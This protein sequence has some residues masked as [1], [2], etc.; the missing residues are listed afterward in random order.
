MGFNK[1][2]FKIIFIMGIIIGVVAFSGCLTDT[3]YQTEN[4][5]FM[6]NF[7]I[8]GDV[9]NPLS[10]GCMKQ[11][12]MNELTVDGE[13]VNAISLYAII[14]KSDPISKN[15][16][17][18]FKSHDGF[19]A[20]ICGNQIQASYIIFDNTDGWCVI[21]LN[22]TAT[23]NV[24]NI[25]EI[26]I[27]SLLDE[28]EWRDGIGIITPYRNIGSKTIGE[29]L[30]SGYEIRRFYKGGPGVEYRIGVHLSKRVISFNDFLKNAPMEEISSAIIIGMNGYEYHTSDMSGYFELNPTNKINYISEDGRLL[31]KGVRGVV[32]N[33][34][35]WRVTD[36]FHDAKYYLE[37]GK[38]VLII[39][40][41]GFGYYQYQHAINNEYAPFLTT[42]KAPRKA[43]TVYRSVTNAG[44]A[45]IITGQLPEYTG[46]SHRERHLNVQSIYGVALDLGLKPVLIDERVKTL[47]IEIDPVF[48]LDRNDDGFTSDEIFESAIKRFDDGYDLMVIHFHDI[49]SVGHLY[50]PFANE[51]MNAITIFDGHAKEL[52]ENWDGKVIIVSD[53]GMHAV[54]EGGVHG[55]T[56]F[57]DMMVPYLV[58]G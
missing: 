34:P 44:M 5:V 41:D 53:H 50:G 13:I 29:V 55:T 26:I 31:I 39:V 35:K 21:N 11:F 47:N 32:L 12:E 57:E 54:P 6:P 52:I 19:G 48:N 33:P 17:I 2:L 38:R 14:E 51:T 3:P 40:A 1:L 7:T 24:D 9:E 22:H 45:S 43:M 15:N 16:T 27:T 30:K 58:I 36:T 49:D 42:L 8:I 25:K 10:I 56:R 37:D 4:I 28:R 20:S 46:V 18:L 23:A